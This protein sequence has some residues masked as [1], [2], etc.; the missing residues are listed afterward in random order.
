MSNLKCL[1]MYVLK[2]SCNILQYNIWFSTSMFAADHHPVTTMPCWIEYLSCFPRW[3]EV[4]YN[5]YLLLFRLHGINP[6]KLLNLCISHTFAWQPYLLSVWKTS[7]HIRVKQPLFKDS[8]TLLSVCFLFFLLSVSLS[9][10]Q[11][12]W[13]HKNTILTHFLVRGERAIDGRT[14]AAWHLKMNDIILTGDVFLCF[15][16]PCFFL[17]LFF[18]ESCRAKT[19]KKRI[20]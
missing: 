2:Y 17:F 20:M 18:L 6:K 14:G 9:S 4:L 7:N 3:S 12:I 13:K 10:E 11:A 8:V 16:F 15:S 5:Y 1:A 19:S